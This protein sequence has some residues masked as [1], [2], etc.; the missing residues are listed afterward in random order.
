MLG[1]GVGGSYCW[2]LEIE[3]RFLDLDIGIESELDNLDI[4]IVC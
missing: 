4:C 1:L 2:F 3:V